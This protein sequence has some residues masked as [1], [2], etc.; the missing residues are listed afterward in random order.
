MGGGPT[1]PLDLL[2]E[3]LPHAPQRMRALGGSMW[4]TIPGGTLLEL[5]PPA[6]TSPELGTL[7]AVRPGDGRFLIHRVVGLRPDGAFLLKGDNCPAPDGWFSPDDIVA[8]VTR[9]D[10]GAGWREVPRAKAPVPPLSRRALRRL[11][12]LAAQLGRGAVH[13][14]PPRRRAH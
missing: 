11:A 13:P 4:P 2:L 3:A 8:R 6:P 12:R 7:V 10:D 9:M 1:L 5:H 14:S